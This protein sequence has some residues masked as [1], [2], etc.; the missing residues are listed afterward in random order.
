MAAG[1]ILSLPANAAGLVVTS[2]ASA[3]TY[4]TAVPFDTVG[5]VASPQVD[6]YVLGLVFQA[7]ALPGND[8]TTEILFD[9]RVSGSTK[10]QVPYTLRQDSSLGYM[11]TYDGRFFFPEPFLVKAGTTLSVR[12]ADGVASA[13]DYNGV[14][15]F[16]REVATPTTV[17]GTPADAGTVT[18]T[19]P[20]L[21]FTGTSDDAIALEYN[22][23]V[24]TVNTFDSQ[25]SADTTIDAVTASG[26]STY[27]LASDFYQGAGQA[28]TGVG[29]TLTK[30]K[31]YLKKTGSPIGN[32][33]AKIYAVT[34]N[35]GT[36]AKPTGTALATSDAFNVTTL[37]GSYVLTT[38]T[39]TG[40]QQITLVAG[41]KYVVTVEYSTSATATGTVDVQDALSHDG[42]SSYLLSG[43]WSLYGLVP[44][45]DIGFAVVGTIA[46]PLVSKFSLTDTGFT[47]GHPFTS[48][49]EKTY[50]VQSALTR[51]TTYYWRVAAV[52]TGSTAYGS[53]SATRSFVVSRLSLLPFRQ[54]QRFF[55][56]RF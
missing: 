40:G 9:L 30:A 56:R 5:G 29:C 27:Q 18:S 31:F 32:A 39:F 38:F 55:S 22:V 53:W 19:T 4:G 43:T 42:N 26:G 24:D 47:A 36:T 34:G 23:Q 44:E 48:G 52:H 17:L 37:T 20:D 1:Q 45:V 46:A 21:K 8:V 7:T 6:I 28:F 25:T 16:Y 35:Y 33:V 49:V 3:W 15:V 13:L 2:S 41:T 12:V 14:K 10:L 50:T 11:K 54:G 51:G